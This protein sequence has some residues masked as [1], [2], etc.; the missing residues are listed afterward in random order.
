[1]VLSR[2]LKNSPTSVVPHNLKHSELNRLQLIMISSLVLPI[3][4]YLF[5]YLSIYL[6]IYLSIYLFVFVILTIG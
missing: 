5:I 3:N 1:M 6:F 4:I 2:R